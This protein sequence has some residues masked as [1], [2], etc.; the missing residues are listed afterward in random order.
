MNQL[1]RA[2]LKSLMAM[3]RVVADYKADFLKAIERSRKWGLGCPDLSMVEV[4]VRHEGVDFPAPDVSE[5]ARMSRQIPVPPQDR[6]GS[7]VPLHVGAA[8][9][10]LGQD[11][12]YQPV[13]TIG[14]VLVDDKPRYQVNRQR[15]RRHLREGP[16]ATGI[17]HIHCWLT[18]PGMSVMDFSLVPATLREQGER[19]DLSR[20]DG[21]AVA[22]RADDL[23]PKFVY[24]PMLVGSEFLWRTGCMEPIGEV[25]FKR[26]FSAWVQRLGQSV[27]QFRGTDT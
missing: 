27:Q 22:A 18:L 26:A 20:R 25:M 21:L 16:K 17:I 4:L 24:K 3:E 1:Q 11:M 7:C 14:D 19:L 23:S 10:L 13:L 9:Q 12:P 2:S 5:V 6:P 15:L 8:T